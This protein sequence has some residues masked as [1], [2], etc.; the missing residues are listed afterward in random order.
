M[1]NYYDRTRRDLASAV[2]NG[3]RPLAKRLTRRAVKLQLELYAPAKPKPEPTSGAPF[4][5]DISFIG[6]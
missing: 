4:N 3:N 2:H 6:R 5:D 1:R